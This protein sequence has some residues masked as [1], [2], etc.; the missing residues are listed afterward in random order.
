MSMIFTAERRIAPRLPGAGHLEI[1]YAD[2]LPATV[3]AELIERSSTGFR[4]SHACARLV[5]GLE[6]SIRRD[7]NSSRARV[8]WTHVLQEHRVSGFLLL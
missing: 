8:I 7:G 4:A 1:M 3:D 5:A 2:P 6:V